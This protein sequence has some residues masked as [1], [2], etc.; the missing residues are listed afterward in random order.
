GLVLNAGGGMQASHDPGL[1][2]VRAMLAPG[3]THETV[4]KALIAEI[5]RIKSGGVTQ[6]EIDTVVSQQRAADAFGR[7]GVSG[8]ASSLCEW[9][10]AGDWTLFVNYVDKMAAVTPADVQRVARTY[11]NEDQSTTGWF[12]PV[13]AQ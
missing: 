12:V 7:D 3:V 5:E 9:I 4:E 11:L 8:I 6:E 2:T 10:A 1:F 13:T